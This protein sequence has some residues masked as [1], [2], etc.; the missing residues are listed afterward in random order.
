LPLSCTIHTEQDISPEDDDI[1][2]SVR[3]TMMDKLDKVEGSD[4]EFSGTMSN[5]DCTPP[6]K[7]YAMLWEEI[8][9]SK[10]GKEKRA[11]IN[12][13]AFCESPIYDYGGGGVFCIFLMVVSWWE[14]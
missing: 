2:A 5:T 11:T 12:W 4:L 6:T 7:E 8:R 1:G 14:W 9:N 13:P 10:A 3:Y